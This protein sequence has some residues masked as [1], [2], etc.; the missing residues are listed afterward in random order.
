V[1]LFA[2]NLMEIQTTRK[3]SSEHALKRNP[4]AALNVQNLLPEKVT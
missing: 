2:Q 3:N 4:S 1:V